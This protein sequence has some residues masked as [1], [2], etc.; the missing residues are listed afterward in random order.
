M[1]V[2]SIQPILNLIGSQNASK[3]SASSADSIFA[4]LLKDAINNTEETSDVDKANT[5]ALLSGEVNN[6]HDITIAQAE[7]ELALDLTVQ[8]RNKVVDAY[9]EIMRMQV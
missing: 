8:I 4:D 7:A 2:S 5:D 1:A 3:G 9:Q 6:L